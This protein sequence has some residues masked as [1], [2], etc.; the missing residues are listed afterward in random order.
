MHHPTDRIAHTM[1]FVTPVLEHWLEREIAQCAHPMSDRSDDPSHHEQTLL[2]RSYI[3]LPVLLTVS[4][5]TKSPASKWCQ[6][7]HIAHC[8]YSIFF[9]SILEGA[10]HSSEAW[11][12]GSLDRSLMGWTHCSISR[13]SQCSTTG[14]TKAVVCVILSVGW[15]I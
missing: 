11:C 8:I 7:K 10:G 15:C 4:L 6:S 12:D 1:A 9:H 14:V 5:S 2:P 13:S 3:S